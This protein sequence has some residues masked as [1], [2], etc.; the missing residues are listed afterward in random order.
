MNI[1]LERGMEHFSRINSNIMDAHHRYET[2]MGKLLW[3][4]GR[5]ALKLQ[6]ELRGETHHPAVVDR[7]TLEKSTQIA[8]TTLPYHLQTNRM[9]FELRAMMHRSW[10]PLSTGIERNW[11]TWLRRM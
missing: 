10:L 8:S 4:K 9:E 6:S 7:M 2:T 1:E 11:V 5:S 3:P